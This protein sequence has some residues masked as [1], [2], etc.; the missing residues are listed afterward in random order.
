MTPSTESIPILD[1]A[2]ALWRRGLSVIPVPRPDG[3]HD[4]KV[5]TIRWAEYQTR[6]PTEDEIRDWF[7]VPQNLAI[8][9]GAISN[10]VVVDA[11]SR[12]ALRWAVR[13]LPYTPWQVRTSRGFH[14]YFR[15]P[16]VPIRNRAKLDT[17]DGRIA[18]DVRGDGGYVIG[19]GSVHASGAVYME[20]GDWTREDVPRSWPGLLQRPERPTRPTSVYSPVWRPTGDVVERARKYL[21]AIPRPEIGQ[22]S[23]EATLYAACRLVRGFNLSEADAA[24]LLWQWAGG[25]PGWTHEWVAQKVQH[26]VRYGTESIGG[27][28]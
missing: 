26:A 15:H 9:T 19:P 4:G 1:Q 18:V 28:A 11:D 20:A 2:L 27:L 6:Q 23:D 24:A 8:I 12:V 13:H 14:L 25:R 7:R 16:G 22:G 3:R 17:R 10:L 5:P 21:A